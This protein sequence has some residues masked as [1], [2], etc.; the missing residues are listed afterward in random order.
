MK[1]GVV[2]P[3]HDADRATLLAAAETAQAGGLNSV[4]V[5][6]HMRGMKIPSRPILE[7]WTSL[8]AVGSKFD[9]IEVGT[10]MMRAGLRP[11]LLAAKMFWSLDKIAPGRVVA[12]LGL[13]D[14]SVK[15]EQSSFGIPQ[16]SRAEKQQWVE[17]TITLIKEQAPSV[18]MIVGG[19]TTQAMKLAVAAGG[20]NFWG[21]VSDFAQR[22]DELR[23]L[24]GGRAVEASWG[25]SFPGKD[26]LDQLK[27]AG[28]D[29]VMIAVGAGN[30]QERIRSLHEWAG[31]LRG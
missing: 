7:G 19:G 15:D 30:Y 28:A 25:G 16:K 10:L 22:L 3:Q 4:W 31:T 27:D 20:W 23:S 1:I 17:E 12:G 13:G 6:D 29:E 26:G 9:S 14:S 21:K 11:P 18:R 24:D 8:V 2:L 5:A